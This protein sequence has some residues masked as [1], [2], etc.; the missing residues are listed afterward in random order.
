MIPRS[1][2]ATL[3]AVSLAP[4]ATTRC[5]LLDDAGLS[6]RQ[7]LLE[8]PVM[9][10]TA[11]GWKIGAGRVIVRWGEDYAGSP[12]DTLRGPLELRE[13][14]DSDQPGLARMSSLAKQP[15]IPLSL[16]GEGEF[17]DPPEGCPTG[18]YAILG[19][20]QLRPDRRFPF[21]SELGA[22]S[23]EGLE[24]V[25]RKPRWT[26]ESRLTRAVVDRSGIVLVG[27]TPDP[28][29]RLLD[30]GLEVVAPAGLEFLGTTPDLARAASLSVRLIPRYGDSARCGI[31]DSRLWNWVDSTGAPLRVARGLRLR[32]E[33]EAWISERPVR[34][35]WG[36]ASL[37][38]RL[39]VR[40]WTEND[41][42][43][44]PRILAALVDPNLATPWNAPR[45]VPGEL[46]LPD[47][48]WRRR[49][50]VLGTDSVRGV[51]PGGKANF[52]VVDSMVLD[53]VPGSS[54]CPEAAAGFLDK[55]LRL[56]RDSVVFA[57][58]YRKTVVGRMTFFPWPSGFDPLE[59]D[60]ESGMR[61]W[62][63]S[64]SVVDTSAWRS[65]PGVGRFRFTGEVGAPVGDSVDLRVMVALDS[66]W[67]PS[68]SIDS[69]PMVHRA[70]WG[71]TIEPGANPRL[72]A[73]SQFLERQ[74][75]HATASITGIES[76][77]T[78]VAEGRSTFLVGGRKMFARS[79]AKSASPAVEATVCR[80]NPALECLPPAGGR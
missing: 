62:G 43:G 78:V 31:P 50:A 23:I 57:P 76:L 44:E 22:I 67:A 9:T 77:E 2:S 6:G 52:L 65:L 33:G 7:A 13:A 29:Y 37:E 59:V 15:N 66:S 36:F 35:Q 60:Q 74:I 53:R 21:R 75:G 46:F 16:T 48:G 47:D 5:L 25:A 24:L 64:P 1:L 12:R 19:S 80:L 45:K 54:R 3:L 39:R 42:G 18:A 56:E 41:D 11:K 14:T 26:G 58:W 71:R 73:T 8:G 51:L 70:A 55:H 28:W 4:A 17:S 79:G 10:R 40:N 63:A 69:F 61:W 68:F 20:P 34:A 30:G 38:G 32:K 72:V 49:A 27:R